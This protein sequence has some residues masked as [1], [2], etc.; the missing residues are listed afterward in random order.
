M[1]VLLEGR[2]VA[3][4]MALTMV[5]EVV[6]AVVKASVE[7]AVVNLVSLGRTKCVLM[8]PPFIHAEDGRKIQSNRVLCESKEQIRITTFPFG[9]KK[10]KGCYAQCMNG[11]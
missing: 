2:V 7:N 9:L 3:L 4:V 8:R 5:L 11:E 10:R 1:K 6:L